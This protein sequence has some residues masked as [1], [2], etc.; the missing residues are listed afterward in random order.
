MGKGCVENLS[1]LGRQAAASSRDGPQAE[2]DR[3]TDRETDRQAD[4]TDTS[5][6][7]SATAGPLDCQTVRLFDSQTADHQHEEVIY[8]TARSGQVSPQ[9]LKFGLDGL[10]VDML[11]SSIDLLALS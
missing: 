6:A 9:N 1:P 10:I 3:Q 4:R 11:A 8:C 5:A 2:I 7:I